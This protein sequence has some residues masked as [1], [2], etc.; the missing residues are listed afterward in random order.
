VRRCLR[1]A[2]LIEPQAM[3]DFAL[4]CR[5]EDAYLEMQPIDD[6]ANDMAGA[7]SLRRLLV[8][9]LI[10][11][12]VDAFELF[13]NDV[14][15]SGPENVSVAQAL[16][17]LRLG[18][19]AREDE[20]AREFFLLGS[21]EDLRSYW[22]ALAS[23]PF[24][25]QLRAFLRRYGHRSLHES[26]S[27]V[28]RFREDPVPILRAVAATV[29]TAEVEMPEARLARQRA[30]AAAAW[31]ALR[32]RLPAWERWLPL[33]LLIAKQTVRT[34]QLL[35][36]YREGFRS[37]MAR[38]IGE[39]RRLELA[40]GRRWQEQEYLDQAADLYWL[41]LDELRRATEERPF[42]SILRSIVRDRKAEYERLARLD[43]PNLML[44]TDG[45]MRAAL[46]P[47]PSEASPEHGLVLRG[48]PVSSGIA[49]GE[50]RVIHHPD[51][52][53]GMEPGT[54]LVCPV[55]GPSWG[56]LYSIAGGLIVEMG[57]AL[58]HGAI[59]AREYGLPTVT[60]IP[61]VTRALRTGDRV[62]LN[63]NQGIIW[64]APERQAASRAHAATDG[65]AE[66]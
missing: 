57:G 20:I 27:S 51:D 8:E 6:A 44:E 37:E 64:R 15:V 28:P 18:A 60:N 45:G 61:G 9:T 47:P 13:L 49:E 19:Q 48:Q 36:R 52:A 42:K 2:E 22:V 10:G 56:P 17:L 62:L 24:L 66:D 7:L 23:S 4:V 39:R 1:R 21:D 43:V 12:Y 32:T 54:I 58:S 59:L 35:M 63:A 3:S 26:D 65:P 14:T 5:I 53:A 33:R 29:R 55:V 16:D 38:M 46:A 31:E 40:L 30:A 34:M 11:R 41:R 25:E 50:V